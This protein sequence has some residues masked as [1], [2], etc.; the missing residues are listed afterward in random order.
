MIIDKDAIYAALTA[1]HTARKPAKIAVERETNVEAITEGLH[2]LVEQGKAAQIGDHFVSDVAAARLRDTARRALAAFHKKHPY[3]RTMPVFLLT[4]PLAKAAT[5]SDFTAL[6]AW[7][8]AEE[9]LVRE[10][11]NVRLPDHT[12]EL[13]PRWEAAA[14]EMLAVFAGGGLIDPPWPGNFKANFPRDV[15][16]A[17]ILDALCERNDLVRIAADIYVPTAA[18]ETAKQVLRTLS[19]QGTILTIGTVRDATGSSRRVVI[20][21]LETLD[22]QGFTE[23]EGEIRFVRFKPPG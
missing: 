2:F 6:L 8:D 21:L 23:R 17:A 11:D 19:E 15:N 14:Q 3:H 9:V 13:P 12:G 5:V 18:F 4:E 1:A 10:G 16:V 7:L 20:P 22:K